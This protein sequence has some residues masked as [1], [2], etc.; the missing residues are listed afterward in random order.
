MWISRET[1]AP[2]AISFRMQNAYNYIEKVEKLSCHLAGNKIEI[3]FFSFHAA[4]IV[5]VITIIIIIK[6]AF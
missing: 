4:R 6:Y 5:V 3:I 1:I 2:A